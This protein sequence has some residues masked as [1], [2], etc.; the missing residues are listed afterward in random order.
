MRQSVSSQKRTKILQKT[1]DILG[2]LRIDET[3]VNGAPETILEQ[4][5]RIWYP[6]QFQ[7]KGM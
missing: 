1:S 7:K 3:N 2:H 4:V 6:V 5:P